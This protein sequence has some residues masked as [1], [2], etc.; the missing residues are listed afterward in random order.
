MGN[1]LA[2][3]GWQLGPVDDSRA[4]RA[5]PMDSDVSV[6]AHWRISA[7]AHMWNGA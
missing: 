4:M 2:A 5:N 7:P 1:L 6:R 3:K